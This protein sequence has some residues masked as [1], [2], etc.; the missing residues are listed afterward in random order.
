MTI[1]AHA[2]ACGEL[3]NIDGIMKYLSDNKL[4]KIVLCPGEPNNTK[5]RNVPMI[6]TLIKSSSLGYRFNRVIRLATSLSGVAKHID[7]QN[8]AIAC[9][10]NDYPDKIMPALV[11]FHNMKVML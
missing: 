11:H 6:S 2:H 3:H 4:D 1:D 10:A 8:E 5:N 9:L 7:N